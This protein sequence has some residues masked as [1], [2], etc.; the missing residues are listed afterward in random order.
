[1][2]VKRIISLMLALSFLLLPLA[3]AGHGQEV[4]SDDIFIPA[5][6]EFK[7]ELLSPLSTERNKKGDAFSC[8]V[9]AP[10]TYQG[11]TV[12]G[13]IK[14]LKG[15]GKIKGDSKIELEFLQ[16]ELAD[17]RTGRFNAQVKEVYDVVDA[18]E[19]GKADSEGL[20]KG[21]STAVA[22]GIIGGSIVTATTLST[23]GPN[24]EFKQ[25]TQFVVL[26]N[27]PSKNKGERRQT[28]RSTPRVSD[29]P[30]L[31]RLPTAKPAAP[32]AS[33]RIYRGNVYQMNIPDNWREFSSTGLVALAP[34]GAIVPFQGKQAFTHC[35]MVGVAPAASRN[36]QQDAGTLVANL[37]RENNYLRQQGNPAYA[38]VGGRTALE[39]NLSGRWPAS[40]HDEAVVVYTTLLST[41]EVFYL[42]AV[43]SQEDVQIA[44]H[45]RDLM[46]K[47]G[48]A[49]VASPSLSN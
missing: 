10:P 33:Y 31:N 34:E 11:A 19:G 1:M 7:L 23:K 8:Q 40:E 47:A 43:S 28:A 4:R 37:L 21:K 42:I 12:S 27:A 35:V 24:L 16:I 6:Q 2:Q 49:T 26:T 14:D 48:D 45:A 30:A 3:Q 32:S 36:L 46:L 39:V 18:A 25:G 17:K 44:R 20:V 29:A 15:S 9:L 13:H 38:V 22:G 5:D 41:G